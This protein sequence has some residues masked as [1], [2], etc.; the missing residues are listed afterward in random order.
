MRT[1]I[2]GS[3]WIISPTARLFLAA[4][5]RE[6]PWTITEVLSG[7]ARGIDT[8]GEQW[9]KA[10]GI[11]V[12]PFAADWYPDGPKGGLDRCAGF[13]RNEEMAVHA[14]ALLAIWDG[15][16]RGTR[17]MIDRAEK[18]RLRLVVKWWLGDSFQF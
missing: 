8:M 2:A 15:Y 3:R 13:R 14:D 16:S 12:K 10:H 11:P 4:S 5:I 1:I 17:D 7:Q 18:H 9:G 6:L